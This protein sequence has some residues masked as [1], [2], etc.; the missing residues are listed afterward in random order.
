[1]ARP[2]DRK[3]PVPKGRYNRSAA[4]KSRRNA[5]LL[6]PSLKL[7]WQETIFVSHFLNSFDPV[8]AYR[9]GFDPRNQ[10]GEP[11]TDDDML[12]VWSDNLL[13]RE[14]VQEAIRVLV[15]ERSQRVLVSSEVLMRRLHR[16]IAVASAEQPVQTVPGGP[17]RFVF[18]GKTALEAIRMLGQEVGMFRDDLPP[19]APSTTVNVL[20]M[21]DAQLLD[22]VQRANLPQQS[23]RRVLP[24]VIDAAT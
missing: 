16:I 9:A 18:D 13:R 8:A 21:S 23:S 22:I 1:M 5:R 3:R 14:N 15:A 19:P 7:D 24:P 10:A 11:V 17:L 20:S 4:Q 2:P 6:D 12:R